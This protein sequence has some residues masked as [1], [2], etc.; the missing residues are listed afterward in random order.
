MSPGA[1]AGN[2]WR[3]LRFL[4]QA[5]RLSGR[6]FV[7]VSSRFPVYLRYVLCVLGFACLVLGVAICVRRAGQWVWTPR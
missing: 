2:S 1:L 6:E 7:F 5:V 3:L 4:H